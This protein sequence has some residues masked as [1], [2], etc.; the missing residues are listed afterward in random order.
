LDVEP[1]SPLVRGFA[2]LDTETND[3]LRWQV[4]RACASVTVLHVHMSRRSALAMDAV[5]K[6]TAA[7]VQPPCD[8]AR[9][10]AEAGC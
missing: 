3:Q 8:V 5:N 2:L 10:A 4:D 7:A 9:L 1:D 6:C